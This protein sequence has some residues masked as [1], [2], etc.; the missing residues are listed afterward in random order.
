MMA[1]S[2]WMGNPRM[3]AMVRNVVSLPVAGPIDQVALHCSTRVTV[4]VPMLS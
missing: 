1:W 4:T 2:C 3:V